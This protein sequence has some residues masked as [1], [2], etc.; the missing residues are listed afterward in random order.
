MVLG[1]FGVLLVSFFFYKYLDFVANGEDINPLIPFL[2]EFTGIAG[3]ILLFPVIYSV[4]IRFPLVA[5]LWKRNLPV[6]LAAVVLLSVTETTLVWVQRLWLFPR[7]GLGEYN[8]GHM[9][10]RYPMEFSNFF[11]FYWVGVGCIYLLHELRFARERELAQARLET[12]LREA[13]LENLRLQLEPHFL[14]NALNAISAA[15]YESP[16]AADEMIGR[17]SD[18]LRQLLKRDQRQ[19]ISLGEEIELIK[20]YTRIMEA[21]L[22]DRLK[23]SIDIA[24]CVKGAL[25]PQLILQPLVE[26]AIKHGMDPVGFKANVS[27]KAQ[28]KDG[29]LLLSVRDHGAGVSAGMEVSAMNGIG[30]HNTRERLRHL[31]NGNTSLMLHNADGGGAIAELRIPFHEAAT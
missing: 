17:L 29:T 28:V 4:A 26:N 3:T 18:L 30:L 16:R 12:T 7:L 19:E 15:V 21:R 5:G 8:Y 1:I 22:E 9:P 13:Q 10:A 31:Y 6:H 24:D 27:V 2:W 25:V 20:L 14:F 11:I 23:V